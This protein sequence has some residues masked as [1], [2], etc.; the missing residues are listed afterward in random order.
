MDGTNIGTSENPPQEVLDLMP[1]TLGITYCLAVRIHLTHLGEWS[2][3][4]SFFWTFW[5]WG[6]ESSQSFFSPKKMVSTY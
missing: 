6:R 2:N 1:T 3:P 4:A 5:C